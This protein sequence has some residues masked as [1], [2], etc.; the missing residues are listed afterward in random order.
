MGSSSDGF[1]TGDRS[2]EYKGG[3][4]WKLERCKAKDVLKMIVLS[5]KP[6]MVATHYMSR[7][8]KPCRAVDCEGCAK[9]LE[10][11]WNGYMAIVLLHNKTKCLIEYTE[12]SQPPLLEAFERHGS[13]RGLQ[14]VMSRP[15]Q[16]DNAPMLLQ[17]AGKL[18][19]TFELPEEPDVFAEM[20]RVWKVNEEGPA[21]VVMGRRALMLKAE[22]EQADRLKRSTVRR[23]G[24]QLT[25]EE[26]LM[27]AVGR[28]KIDAHPLKDVLDANFKQNGKH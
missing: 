26:K 22:K 25:D 13:I 3:S 21:A 12:G 24:V 5:T 7:A 20:C 17:V 14:L 6:L 8:G 15:R 16:R 18:E 27:A 19:N 4:V 2:P 1:V 10:T 28:E 11:R 23:G 9:R